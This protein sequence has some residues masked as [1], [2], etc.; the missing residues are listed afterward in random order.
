M[1][2]RS[3]HNREELEALLVT[4]GHRHIVEVGFA[5]FS[6]RAVAKAAGYSV[7]TIY[8]VFGSVD[9]LLLA[10]N[11][12]TVERWI[13]ALAAA[14]DGAG[15]DRIAD[16][17]RA[18]FDFARDHANA[19]A[20]LYDHRLPSDVAVPDWY[21]AV[22]GRLTGIMRDE[23]Q[24]VLPRQDAAAIAALSRSLLACVHGHCVFAMSGTFAQLDEAAPVE[25]ALARV[26]EGLEA[27][28]AGG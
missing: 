18:Y 28:A 21:V 1:A 17:V 9:G 16:L 3:D 4:E 14:L 26:R 13:A 22:V 5:R 27:A 24:R 11:A 25:A 20:A 2:R 12:R 8:N 19:W 6:A 15:E 10:I 23:V 7:G